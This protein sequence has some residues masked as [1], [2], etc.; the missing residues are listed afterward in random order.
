MKILQWISSWRDWP[1]VEVAFVSR[2]WWFNLKSRKMFCLRLSRIRRFPRNVRAN[3]GI[4][5][6]LGGATPPVFFSRL[7]SWIRF[8]S[9]YRCTLKIHSCRGR[10]SNDKIAC[11]CLL[12][13]ETRPSQFFSRNLSFV[14]YTRSRRFVSERKQYRVSKLR[15]KTWNAFLQNK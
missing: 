10:T 7:F 5:L 3:R 2:D 14:T 8:A 15:Y 4:K 6:H 13:K 9:A 12:S 1:V 11:I